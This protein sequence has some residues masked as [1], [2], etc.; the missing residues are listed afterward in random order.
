MWRVLNADSSK[1][2]LLKI[3]E[4]ISIFI[5]CLYCQR[6]NI[7]GIKGKASTL[8]N[9]LMVCLSYN[10]LSQSQEAM[11]AIESRFYKY[12]DKLFLK[13]IYDVSLR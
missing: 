11:D 9:H 7:R 8:G 10:Y 13:L 2:N 4:F 3:S 1:K 6:V 5:K 12:N